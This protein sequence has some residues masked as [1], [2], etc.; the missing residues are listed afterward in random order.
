M[1]AQVARAHCSRKLL[2]HAAR[3]I[4]R[5]E[6]LAQA[7]RAC[8]P[9]K[10]QTQAESITSNGKTRSR[11]LLAQSAR[12]GTSRKLVDKQLAQ[13]ARASTRPKLACACVCANARRPVS[14]IATITTIIN[15]N[16][17]NSFVPDRLAKQMVCV[18]VCVCVC[19][20][21]RVYLAGVRTYA[22]AITQTPRASSLRKLA[23]RNLTTRHKCPRASRL[24][25]SFAQAKT[26]AGYVKKRSRKFL[27]QSFRASISRNLIA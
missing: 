1:L 7:A 4:C 21:A 13:P 19:M 17:H 12:A 20:R 22:D 24:R 14:D 27:A 2:A 18:Y 16:T 5:C 23:S 25:K 10:L 6:L 26:M 11:R 3:A 9:R 8:D 15:T